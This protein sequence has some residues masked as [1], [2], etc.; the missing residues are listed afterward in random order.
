MG[1]ATIQAVEVAKRALDATPASDRLE[2]G[3]ALFAAGSAIAGSSS[4][5]TA[6]ADGSAPAAQR[7]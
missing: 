1:S 4:L 3:R 7:S 2:T 6:L 5:L